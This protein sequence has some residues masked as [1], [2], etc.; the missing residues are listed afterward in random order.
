MVS[1]FLRIGSGIFFKNCRFMGVI[2]SC[3]QESCLFH[4][5]DHFIILPPKAILPIMFFSF[6]HETALQESPVLI[7]DY[8][9]GKLK[10]F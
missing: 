6:F 9:Y 8:P 5:L 2:K 10:F 4:D 7:C 3:T 1:S